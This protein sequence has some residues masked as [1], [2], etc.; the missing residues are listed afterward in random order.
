MS[1]LQRATMDSLPADILPAVAQNPRAAEAIRCCSWGLY[2]RLAPFRRDGGDDS[3]GGNTITFTNDWWTVTLDECEFY[4][5]EEFRDGYYQIGE[6]CRPV[7]CDEPTAHNTIYLWVDNSESLWNICV[8]TGD[9]TECTRWGMY[10]YIYEC[11]WGSDDDCTQLIKYELYNTP[12]MGYAPFEYLL[13]GG[14]AFS[15][16]N[17]G[18]RVLPCDHQYLRDAFDVL[19]GHLVFQYR[20]AE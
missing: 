7:L 8:F 3:S 18:F 16:T 14:E 1:S 17:G 13:Y 19:A 10:R 11:K 5:Y 12:D 20:L 9:Q 4:T 6:F 15:F 2:K